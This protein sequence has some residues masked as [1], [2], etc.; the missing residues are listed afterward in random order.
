M[1]RQAH[2]FKHS[3]CYVVLQT[4]ARFPTKGVIG[5]LFGE[6]LRQYWRE[7]Y[8]RTRHVGTFARV[9]LEERL[10]AEADLEN[11]A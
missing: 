3:Y 10:I 6:R 8:S 11:E 4:Q 1:P 9:A 2:P 7:V 5:N